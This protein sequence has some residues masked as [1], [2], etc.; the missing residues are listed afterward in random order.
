M[1]TVWPTVRPSAV[2][3]ITVTVLPDSLIW[4]M[5]VVALGRAV[6]AVKLITALPGEDNAVL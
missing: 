2:G 3:V 6:A 5:L 1:V 4:L